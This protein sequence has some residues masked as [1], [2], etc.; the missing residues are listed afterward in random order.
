MTDK[1]L[2]ERC[3]IAMGWK[4]LGPCSGI[5]DPLNNAADAL[6]LV[7]KF[8]MRIGYSHGWSA[9]ILNEDDT[10]RA[11]SF[12]QPDVKRAIVECAGN[13]EVRQSD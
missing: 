9:L 6:A 8:R 4:H 13:C 12:H 3:A 1:E 2:T 7:E 11:G 10:L 5:P